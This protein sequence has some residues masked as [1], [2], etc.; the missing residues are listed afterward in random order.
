M[1]TAPAKPAHSVGDRIRP[2]AG[3]NE[4]HRRAWGAAGLYQVG[5]FVGHRWAEWNGQFR[6]DARRFV[7]GD[8]G[9]VRKLA[10]RL[11]ASPDLY[12]QPDREPNRSINFVAC[13]DGFTLGDLVSYNDKHNEAN[14]E[15]NGDG[16]GGNFSWNC[17]AEG[18]TDDP[19]IESLRLRQIKNL[20]TI[21]F[22]SQGTPMLSMGDEARRTQ[23]G[24]NNA[25]C[26]D[27]EISWFD[28]DNLER[29]A[30]LLR[31][32]RELIRLNRGH[33]VF[34]EEQF[35]TLGRRIT[36]HGVRLRQPD[37]SDHSHSL[38]FSLDDADSGA[39]FYVMLNAYWEPLEFEL[40]PPGEGESWRRVVDTALP[41]PDDFC[42]PPPRLQTSRLQTSRLQTSRLQTAPT[43]HVEARAAVVLMMAANQ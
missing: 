20:L 9:T 24:N 18:P 31:F 37:W 30:G 41:P 15:S 16:T 2:G 33:A 38:A 23:R 26:Q 7:R 27:N 8:C 6:D 39:H 35:W 13:H 5:S 19:A 4:N 1:G 36:W 43:Y 17:G 11:T 10:A 28:W 14:G 12:P 21:L 34:Q 32:V 42:D 3:R 25:Y 22:V 29:H 40:P